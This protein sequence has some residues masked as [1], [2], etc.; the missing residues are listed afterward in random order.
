[1]KLQTLTTALFLV[2]SFEIFAQNKDIPKTSEMRIRIEKDENGKKT[3]TEKVINTSK[4]TQT[5]QDK[6]ASKIQDSVLADSPKM[7]RVKVMIESQST[8]DKN[9]DIDNFSDNKTITVKRSNKK[10][11]KD[12]GREIS[13]RD[14]DEEQPQETF[15]KE[16][17]VT[18]DATDGSTPPH[19]IMQDMKGGKMI[20]FD[21]DEKN[22]MPAKIQNIQTFLNNPNNEILNIRFNAPEKGNVSISIINTESQTIVKEEISDFSG[23]YV[24]QLKIGKQKGTLFLMVVQNGDGNVK[25]VVV[26]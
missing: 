12:D 23:A 11:S 21:G 18:V 2:L 25:R 7:A 3:I 16:F 4:M 10:I 20:F 19:I 14:F 1:M 9:T 22:G 6:L 8:T 26:E 5:Q 24:G 15:E 13:I 17:K